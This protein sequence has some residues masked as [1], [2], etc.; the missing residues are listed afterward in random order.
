MQDAQTIR[1]LQD[2]EMEASKAT[3]KSVKA[4]TGARERPGTV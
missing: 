3:S 4:G 2:V 1:P